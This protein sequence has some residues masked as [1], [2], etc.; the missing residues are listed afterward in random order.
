MRKLVLAVAMLVLFPV[1]A[2]AA[3]PVAGCGHTSAQ[4]ALKQGA[5]G[6]E[7]VEAQ[8]ELNLATKASRYT[9]IGADGSFGPA[10]DARVR[11]FQRCAGLSVDGEIGPN[12]WGALNSWSAHPKKCATQG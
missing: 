4:P 6:T 11:V 8:C 7:V 2:I 10:T 3:E 1:V 9:P 5:S 12:T